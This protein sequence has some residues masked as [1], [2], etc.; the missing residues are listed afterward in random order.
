MTIHDE[1]SVPIADERARKRTAIGLVAAR[2]TAKAAPQRPPRSAEPSGCL[3]TM[4]LPVVAMIV[5][6]LLLVTARMI[7]APLTWSQVQQW[8]A[9]W[10][11]RT[12]PIADAADHLLVADDFVQITGVLASTAQPGEWLA[13]VRPADGVYHLSIAQARLVWSTIGASAL[14][15]FFAEAALTIDAATP[16]GV[17]GLVARRQDAKNAYLFAINGKGEFQVQLLLDGKL[18]PL[19]PW[20]A[21]V[22]VHPAGATNQLTIEDD[23]KML[24]FFVNTLLFYQTDLAELPAGDVGV[25]GAAPAGALA[26]IDVDWLRIYSLPSN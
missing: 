3:W 25:F 16:T 13:Q 12:T 22:A 15:P 19:T 8:A 6:T 11:G 23:G 20:L 9:A 17:T 1:P 2:P 5:V 14:K 21:D 24:R 7:D 4:V 26:E 18:Q 10:L